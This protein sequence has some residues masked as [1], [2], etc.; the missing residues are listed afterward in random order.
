MGFRAG[1]GATSA[2][3][4]GGRFLMNGQ[5][6][7]PEVAVNTEALAEEGRGADT[8][9]GARG[10]LP[11]R[12]RWRKSSASNPNGNCVELAAMPAQR[13][14]IRNSRDPF[15]PV[16]VVTADELAALLSAIRAGAFDD[17]L[18]GEPSA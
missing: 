11:G 2:G 17:L 4:L 15:G 16:L 1:V 7:G 8:L 6:G 12:L 14:A 10:V 13:V 5:D 9:G 18:A 3:I